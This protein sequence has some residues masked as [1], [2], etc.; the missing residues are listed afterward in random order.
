MEMTVSSRALGV[1]LLAAVLLVVG[2]ASGRD[3][4][5]RRLQARA[6]YEQGLAHLSEQRISLGLSSLQEAVRLDP[7][8]A[9]YQNSIGVIFLHY[10]GKPVEAQREFEKALAIDPGYAEAQANVGVALAQQGRWSEAVSAYQRALSMPVYPTPEVAYANLGWAYLNLNRP[11][12]AEEAYRAAIRLQPRFVQAF[13]FLG[14]L[15]EQEGRRTEARDA[16]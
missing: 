12:E 2:C 8:S 1:G 16:L 15:L 7:E 14:V 5:V 4:E 3:Q 6:M 11:R 13:Y 10:L 9:L